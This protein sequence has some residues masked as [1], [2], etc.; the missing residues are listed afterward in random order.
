MYPYKTYQ[1]EQLLPLLKDSDDAAF[2]EIYRRYWDRLYVVAMHR[3]ADMDEARELV[4]DIFFHLWK[5]RHSLELQYSLNTYLSVAVK[6]EVLGRLAARERSQRYRKYISRIWQEAT[7][8][9]ENQVQFN[10]L[11]EQ[12]AVLVNALPEKC[13]IVFQLSR[14]QGYS[15]KKIA[16]ELGIAE[17]TVEAHLS[18]ALRKLRAGL[19]HFFML[20]VFFL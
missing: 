7:P 5:R 17:K 1:D 18:A 16:A 19:H 14:D 3:L 8:D 4:Q 13:R 6:Y 9:T 11:R 12:L 2:T 15:Q 20:L 10:E